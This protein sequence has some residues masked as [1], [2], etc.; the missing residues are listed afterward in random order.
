MGLNRTPTAILE[1]R[2]SFI[3]HKN[4]KEA[5][6]GEPVVTKKLG[7]PPKTFTDEQKKTMARVRQNRSG[8]CRN[9][10][11][12]LGRGNRCLCDG[13]V[14]GRYY[15]WNRDG[16]PDEPAFY[17]SGLRPPTAAG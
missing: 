7:S 4:R 11:G 8:R 5:R 14:P 17:D 16:A 10:C 15:L 3:G 6:A 2:G 13:E 9:L 1:A 12:P